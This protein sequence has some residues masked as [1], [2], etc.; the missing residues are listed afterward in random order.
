MK[1]VFIFKTTDSVAEIF[2]KTILF[3]TVLLWI[4]RSKQNWM[5][6]DG[7][8]YACII[9]L[10]ITVSSPLLC[11]KKEI[12]GGKKGTLVKRYSVG[13]CFLV[14]LYTSFHSPHKIQ[15]NKLNWLNVVFNALNW[16]CDI[17]ILAYILNSC[18]VWVAEMK[19]SFLFDCCSTPSQTKSPPHNSMQN[20]TIHGDTAS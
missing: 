11:R 6:M 7:K 10:S 17:I 4:V 8:R 15:A 19:S 18:L 9:I 20:Q 13:G 14:V 5:Q 2:G 16:Y 1:V 12:K 3:R